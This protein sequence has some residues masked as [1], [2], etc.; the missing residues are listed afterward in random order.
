MFTQ[1]FHDRADYNFNDIALFDELSGLEEEEECE[2]GDGH[3]YRNRNLTINSLYQCG[4]SEYLNRQSS[5]GD[6]PLVVINY[7]VLL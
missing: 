3:R 5:D 1:Q 6:A 7:K 2:G 4:Y